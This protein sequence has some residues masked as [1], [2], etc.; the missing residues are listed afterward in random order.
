M[1]MHF[2][3]FRSSVFTRQQSQNSDDTCHCSRTPTKLPDISWL[4]LITTSIP[5]LSRSVGTVV[6]FWETSAMPRTS[7]EFSRIIPDAPWRNRT[8]DDLQKIITERSVVIDILCIWFCSWMLY[9]C[10]T[11]SRRTQSHKQFSGCRCTQPH[12]ITNSLMGVDAHSHT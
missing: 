2:A 12:T 9:L 6:P 7:R 3:F 1:C 10:N 8:A 4:S 5:K 11:W